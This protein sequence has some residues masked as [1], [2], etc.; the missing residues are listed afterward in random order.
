MTLSTVSNAVLT[1]SH[2][3]HQKTELDTK[4]TEKGKSTP[5]SENNLSRKKFGDNVTLSQSRE[6]NTSSEVIDEKA[7]EKLLHQTMKSILAHSK[8]AV[9][10]QTTSTQQVAQKFLDEN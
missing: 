1:K 8:Q 2:I 3:S 5:S 10:A 9:S 6:M 4:Q 7:A